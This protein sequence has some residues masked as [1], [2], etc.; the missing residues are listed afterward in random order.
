MQDFDAVLATPTGVPIYELWIQATRSHAVATFFLVILASCG[1]FAMIGCQQTASRLCWSMARDNALVGSKWLGCIHP[2]LGV[3][4]WALVVNACVVFIIGC[5]YLG[6]TTAF[7]AMIGTGLILQQVSYAFPAALIMYRKRTSTYLPGSRYF[8][9]GAFGWVA[10]MVT[11]AFAV[12]VFIFFQFPFVMPVTASNM[13]YACVVL[14]AMAMFT[15]VNWFVY[16]KER[17][18]GPRLPEE[19]T[20]DGGL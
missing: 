2:R 5:V 4:V 3:P 17:Y 20:L 11:V 1:I 9:L 7:N 10:N 14:G 13:N 18:H 8:K 16:A 19:L 12:I 15:V 6:S